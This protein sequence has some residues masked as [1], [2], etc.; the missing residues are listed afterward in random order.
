MSSWCRRIPICASLLTLSAACADST[1]LSL[2]ADDASSEVG[3]TSPEAGKSEGGG[4]P[5]GPSGV[6]GAAPADARVNVPLADATVVGATSGDGGAADATVAEAAAVDAST[7]VDTGPSEAAAPGDAGGANTDAGAVDA[8]VLADAAD[9]GGASGEAGPVEASASA[10]DSSSDADGAAVDLLLYYPFD[11]GAGTIVTDRSGRSL[12]GNYE[13]GADGGSADAGLTAGW[14]T[15]GRRGG[16]LAL[17]GA[18]DVT[19]PSGVLTGVSDLTIAAWVKLDSAAPWSRVFDV[20]HAPDRWSFLTPNGGSGVSWHVFGG[21]FDD[22]GVREVVV[23]PGTPLPTSVWKHVAVTSSGS[24]Y[25]MYIDGFPAAS[26]TNGP[27]ILPSEMEPLAP[28][29]WSGKSRFG[30]DPGLA[31]VLDE[32]RIYG[33]VLSPS[34]VADVAWPKA[35]YSYWRFDEG[36]GATT[37]DSSD[38]AIPTTLVGGAT[39]TATGRL[40]AAVDLPGGAPGA[41]GPYVALADNPLKSCTS[42]LTVASWLRVHALTS[43]SRLFDFGTTTSTFIYLAPTD[44]AGMHFAMVAPGGGTHVFDLVAPAPFPGDDAWHHVAVTVAADGT[45]TLY[46]DGAP[47]KAGTSAV[48]KPS[49]FNAVN[50]LSFGKSRFPDPYLDAAIDDMRIACR[51]YTAAEIVNL[52]YRP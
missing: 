25:Q 22:G 34:E 49:D 24:T 46:V 48:V 51:A 32:L 17:A 35:D 50:D 3:S 44:G 28:E 42:E 1:G 41:T 21:A 2:S 7:A 13:N 30:A 9:D 11:D 38:N 52:A 16:A 12:D 20:G 40:G 15:N 31:G 43:W 6:D 8:S 47:V 36:A 23:S 33:R 37:A 14:T 19:I 4:G 10:N 45:V 18:Q 27:V 26:V 29:S 5:A 39:W